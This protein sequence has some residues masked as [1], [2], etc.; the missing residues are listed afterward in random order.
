LDDE[1][2]HIIYQKHILDSSN[3]AR[4]YE[5]IHALIKKAN[6][7]LNDKIPAAPDIEKSTSIGSFGAILE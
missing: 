3:G 5:F 4:A 7:Q 2:I 1:T 6:N